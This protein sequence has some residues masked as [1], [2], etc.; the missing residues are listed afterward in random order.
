M[1]SCRRVSL[2][3]RETRTTA[4]AAAVELLFG[5]ATTL[6][7]GQRDGRGYLG[8]T[9]M[10]FDLER[11]AAQVCDPCDAATARRLAE[12]VAL[13]DGVKQRA[14]AIGL[15]AAERGAGV[16]LGNPAIDVRVRAA[17]KHLHIDVDV[18]GTVSSA[19]GK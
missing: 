6:D 14:R 18:E 10:T 11:V 3:R 5:L 2:F 13:D 1:A 9:M 16:R 8:S 15:D 17:G 4:S 7:E 19:G 12:L